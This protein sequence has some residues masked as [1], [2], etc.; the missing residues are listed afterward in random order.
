MCLITGIDKISSLDKKYN[1]AIYNNILVRKNTM[2]SY[3]CLH[4]I[5]SGGERR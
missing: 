1:P 3:N 5:L 4:Y 2:A